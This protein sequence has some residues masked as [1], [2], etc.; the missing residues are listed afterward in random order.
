MRV[1]LFTDY[2]L[3]GVGGTES[4]VRN[5]AK[6][7]E[8][9]G[10]K[11]TIICP[12]YPGHEVNEPNIVRLSAAKKLSVNGQPVVFATAKNKQTVNSL[13]LDIVHAH[14]GFGIGQLA[15]WYSVRHEVPFFWTYHLNTV[16]W[17]RANYRR[18]VSPMS[19]A[20]LLAV[21]SA[22]T[23]R[24]GLK[25][26][27]RP[28]IKAKQRHERWMW[29]DLMLLA[30]YTSKVF[31]P[32]AHLIDEARQMYPNFNY[33]LLPNAIDIEDY[34]PKYSG[35]DE[36]VKFLWISRAAPEKRPL[37]FLQALHELHSLT[38][39]PFEADIIGSGPELTAL[40]RFTAK[41]Q[42]HNVRIHGGMPPEQTLNFY[43]SADVF[44]LTSY[45]FD[46]QPMV[47]AE[48]TAAGLPVVLCD[49]LLISQVAPN[50]V[51]L[52]KPTA[53]SLAAQLLKTM[54]KKTPETARPVVRF[55]RETYGLSVLADKLG[56]AYANSRA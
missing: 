43:K 15:A 31:V 49:D 21:S 11:V 14:T 16:A 41:Y 44:V 55:A 4:S 27:V 33:S 17:M 22:R 9:S 54:H 25:R 5:Y 10:H 1:G 28:V 36:P 3:P 8:N 13:N 7:L 24:L 52:A 45:R 47:L 37:L 6:A 53:G 19:A 46:N 35:S 26:K 32:S 12:A 56:K 38:N 29:K 23:R 39:K 40:R 20:S 48:A 30:P 50:H 51:F 2:Y 18:I 42:M 34:A